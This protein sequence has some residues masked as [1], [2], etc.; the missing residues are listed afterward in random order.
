M[1]LART[2][3]PSMQHG[4]AG[5]SSAR[6]AVLASG[7][8]SNLQAL[9]DACAVGY[10]DAEVVCVVSDRPGA[11]ALS[12]A[13]DASVPQ[14]VL[15]PGPDADDD[16][17]LWDERLAEIVAEAEPDWVVL[18]GFMRLLS[19]RFL[20]RF[21]NRVVNVHPALPGE[22]PGTRAIERA[23]DEFVDGHRTNTGVMVHLV[24]DEGVDSGPVVAHETV[25]I[26]S[27]DSLDSL[28]DRMHVTEHR[29]LVAALQGLIQ[30]TSTQR[31]PSPTHV[32]GDHT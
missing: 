14:V 25:P 15:V 24:P 20:D 6:I 29:L 2:N 17:R 32:R 28:T 30:R 13:V 10:L 8:G 7:N 11:R 4:P 26:V 1:S 5:G 3:A 23:F 27:S 19:S 18:A 31:N 22:L 9:L 21:P 12:R 16:R